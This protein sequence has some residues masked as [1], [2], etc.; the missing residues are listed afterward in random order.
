MQSI[1]YMSSIW[2]PAEYRERLNLRYIQMCVVE[3]DRNGTSF[4]KL[5]ITML[6]IGSSR[7]R[8]PREWRIIF[9]GKIM[10]MRLAN[11]PSVRDLIVRPIST[12][13]DTRIETY[14]SIFLTIRD[15]FS[16]VK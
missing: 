5:C 4:L 14:F 3:G 1:K 12:I 11:S 7:S 2:R 15:R 13:V 16:L 10:Q 8:M 9:V 6:E